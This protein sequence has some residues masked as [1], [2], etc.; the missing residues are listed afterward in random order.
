MRSWE[1]LVVS[2]ASVVGGGVNAIA[3]GGTLLT[4]PALIWLGRDPVLANATNALGLLPGTVF[5]ALGFRAELARSRAWVALLLLPS[6]AGGIAGAIL[7]LRTPSSTFEVVVPWLVLAATLLLAVQEPLSARLRQRE[8]IRLGPGWKVLAVLF[9]VGVG[10]YGGYFGAGIGI[11]MLA[12]L[13]LLGMRDLHQMNGV[14]NLLAA[15][16]NGIA[17]VWFIISGAVLWNDAL[18]MMVG[19]GLGGWTAAHL[20]QRL[21]R[22]VVRRAVITIGLAMAASLALR[23][24]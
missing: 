11:L 9:Q 6:L 24:R 10:V 14:K 20:A 22:K 7:L 13:G 19:A 2:G 12:A 21:G 4:F 1:L 16:I 18:I 23:L 15:A 17:I 5:G 3:G 8:A